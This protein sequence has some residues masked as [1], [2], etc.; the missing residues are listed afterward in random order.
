M[1]PVMAAII[2]CESALLFEKA[3]R[4]LHHSFLRVARPAAVSQNG[5][6]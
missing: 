4:K 6:Q 3:Q 2:A 5:Y 1:A